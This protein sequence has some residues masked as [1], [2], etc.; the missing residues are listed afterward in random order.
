MAEFREKVQGLVA[1]ILDSR[2]A[3]LIDISVRNEHGG[4]L[5]QVFVDTDQ[6]ITIEQCAEISR[7]LALRM[8]RENLI[9]SSYRLEVSSPGIDR[10][11]RLL[12]QYRKNIGRSYKVI[13]RQF[14]TRKT[15]VGRLE[16]IVGNVLTFRTNA[17]EVFTVDFSQIIESQE[18]LPW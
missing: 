18:E 3:F 14:D 5:L 10:P 9:Q 15:F 17:G 2:N 4:K 7:E 1:P 12:R 13:F 8:D 16:S 6:G 11:L